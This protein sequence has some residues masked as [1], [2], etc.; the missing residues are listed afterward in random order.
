MHWNRFIRSRGRASCRCRTSAMQRGNVVHLRHRDG[1][2]VL[3][4]VTRTC[5]A[6]SA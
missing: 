6:G 1:I 5:W 2:D 4:Q 3:V